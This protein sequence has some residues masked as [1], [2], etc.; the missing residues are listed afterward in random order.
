MPSRLRR[1]PQTHGDV[2]VGAFL[3]HP[4]LQ[5]FAISLRERRECSTL[6]LRER[7]TVVDCFK[8]DISGEQTGH[9]E[10]T[11]SSVLDSPLPQ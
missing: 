5:Q 11:A 8:S 9:T 7:P 6:R 1:T 2:A 10:P 4:Q 3:D